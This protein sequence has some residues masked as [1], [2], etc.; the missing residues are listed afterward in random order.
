MML[1][2]N[3][4]IVQQMLEF[5]ILISF[6]RFQSISKD[7][8]CTNDIVDLS[9]KGVIETQSEVVREVAEPQSNHSKN[10]IAS[11]QNAVVTLTSSE[12]ICTMGTSEQST[13]TEDHSVL[14]RKAMENEDLD[15][16]D[17]QHEET[18]AVICIEDSL[19][20][21]QINEDHNNEIV[22]NDKLDEK[23]LQNSG[24]IIEDSLVENHN[25]HLPC[26]HPVSDD[27]IEKSNEIEDSL[28][29]GTSLPLKKR[30]VPLADKENL[31]DV[32]E[33]IS[34]PATQ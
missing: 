26:D 28:K 15:A 29:A 8:S 3:R 21:L 19:N 18:S 34:Y 11:Q 32:K 12:E 24:C 31:N 30:E 22:A 16:A 9:S 27:K 10:D 14:P 5:E 7:E 4:Y 6:I 17:I 25:L 13:Y 2:Q 20:N 1:K 23:Q 33:E